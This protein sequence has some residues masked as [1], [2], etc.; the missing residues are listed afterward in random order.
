MS[1]SISSQ[2]KCF[3][4]SVEGPLM[5]MMRMMRKTILAV[6]LGAILLAV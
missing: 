3:S 1:G 2:W 6:M 4:E 5:R